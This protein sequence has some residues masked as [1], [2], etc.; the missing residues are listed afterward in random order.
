[1]KVLF[2]AVTLAALA[3]T[4]ALAQN[5]RAQAMQDYDAADGPGYGAGP[6]YGPGPAYGYRAGPQGYVV[7]H[8]PVA[9]FE[10]RIVGQDP[11]PNVVQ[12]LEKDPG[13]VAQ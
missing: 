4:P 9:T 8:S 10:G 7:G 2:A 13:G 11:D 1:M 3:A 5:Y 6:A 12:Q